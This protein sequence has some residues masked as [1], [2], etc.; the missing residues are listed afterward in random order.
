SGAAEAEP[1]F[2]KR[3][4][5]EYMGRR[6]YT[7]AH[8]GW[9]FIVLDSVGIT[10][11]RQYTGLVDAEQLIWLK[12]EL[13]TIGR[14]TPIILITHIPLFTGYMQYGSLT[15]V[16]PQDALV[17]MNARDLADI[18]DGYNVKAVLQGHLHVREVIDNRRGCQ[19]ITSGAVCGNWWRG[20]R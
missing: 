12:N 14:Q 6:Y 11:E 3:M 16:L 9:R 2:G 5:E 17:V 13:N 4:F 19:Y 1:H 10:A 8:K 15:K 7:F 20:P 18:I